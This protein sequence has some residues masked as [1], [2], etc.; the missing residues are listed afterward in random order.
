MSLME[1]D[2]RLDKDNNLSDPNVVTKYRTAADIANNVMRQILVACQTGRRVV[3]LCRLGDSLISEATGKIFKKGNLERGSAYPTCV[4]LNEVVQNFSALEDDGTVL[5]DGDVVKI[6]LGVHIDGYISSLAHTTIINP[7]PQQP[8]T[9]RSADVVCAAHY[10]AQVALRLLHPGTTSS[11]ITTAIS[12]VASAFN[13]SPVAGTSSHQIKRFILEAGPEIPNATDDETQA[14]EF[15]I[16]E[17]EAYTI[18]VV[19]STSAGPYREPDPRPLIL[20]RDVNT[21]YALKLKSS[22]AAYSES[23]KRYGV[24]PFATRELFGVDPKFRLGVQECVAHGVLRPRLV[25]VVAGSER[26]AR[27]AFTVLVMSSGPLIITAGDLPM[28][29]V[30]SDFSV[31]AAGYKDVLEGKARTVKTKALAI[32]EPGLQAMDM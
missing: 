5:K 23:A 3:D 19:L 26:V 9:G 15:E 18:D 31:D 28:P 16:T 20:Q 27:F 24:F 13:C 25:G 8:I 21:T 29:Y 30:H 2:A 11:D 12:R 1:V 22:R 4:C 10:A 6:N 32:T 17:G 7:T 14:E